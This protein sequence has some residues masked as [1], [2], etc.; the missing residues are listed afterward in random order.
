MKSID[1]IKIISEAKIDNKVYLVVDL[2]SACYHNG[3]LCRY[4]LVDPSQF[5]K[6]H[7]IQNKVEI[8]D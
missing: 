4:H 1:D 6:S 3:V 7:R 8:V 5:D 2:G